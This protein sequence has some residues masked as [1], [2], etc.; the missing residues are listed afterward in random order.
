[1]LLP[2]EAI[3]LR[4]AVANLIEAEINNS[5]KGAGNPLDVYA[6]EATLKESRKRFNNIV[7]LLQIPLEDNNE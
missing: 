6:I 7:A 1:M 2:N 5:W 3:E 4:L